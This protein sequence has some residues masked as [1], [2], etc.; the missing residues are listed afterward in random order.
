MLYDHVQVNSL[1]RFFW[2]A[3]TPILTVQFHVLAILKS[4]STITK[5]AIFSLKSFKTEDLI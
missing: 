4:P 1:S 3:M 2:T 5:T